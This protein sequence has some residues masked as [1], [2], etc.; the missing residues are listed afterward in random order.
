MAAERKRKGKHAAIIPPK[1]SRK[2][3]S[4][5]LAEETLLTATKVPYAK[6]LGSPSTG[7][8]P[9]DEEEEEQPDELNY[10]R[11]EVWVTKQLLESMAKFD[12]PKRTQTYKER[13]AT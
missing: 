6:G 4:V 12:D 2:T 3:V 10:E 1:R 9:E 13:G 11:E 7:S 5:E 8:E